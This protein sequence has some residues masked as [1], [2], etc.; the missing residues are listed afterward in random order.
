MKALAITSRGIEDITALEIKELTNT[1]A[2]VKD[3]CV[4]FNIKKLEDLCLLCY[5]AQSVEKI[6]FLLDNFNFKD[7][8]KEIKKAIAKIDFSKWLDKTT[9][10]RVT[11]KL[12]KSEISKGLGNSKNFQSKLDNEDLHSEETA[13]S[14][15]ALIIK[16][17]KKNKKY[18]QKVELDNPDITFLIF[19]N[20][21]QAY[22][23]IDFSGR[24]L[25]KREYKLFAHPAAL[26]STIAYSLLRIADLKEKQIML[27]PFCHSGE[28]PIEAALFTTNFPV[29]YYSKEKFAFTK[30]KPLKKFNFTKFFK[31]I[32]KKI[33]KPKKPLVN[34][35]DNKTT[36]LNAAKKNAKIAGIHKALNFSRMETEFLEIKLDKQSADKIITHPPDPTRTANPKDIEKLYDEFFYQSEFILKK[37]GKIL[38][39]TKQTEL[40]KEAAK[41]HKFKPEQEREVWSGKQKF[42]V[43]VFS[44]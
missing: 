1:K 34:C 27:D 10:F 23:G 16:N 25:H 8:N 17:I 5:K 43:V 7:F 3:S 15:G 32:D 13:A 12:L 22:F 36:N 37:K 26:R 31:D 42:E 4:I 9:T 33:T 35:F 6:L 21:N 28:I 20:K 19:I 11:C 18:N 41:K 14:V 29:N 24:D 39:I 44:K 38:T 2:E 40:L 30:F